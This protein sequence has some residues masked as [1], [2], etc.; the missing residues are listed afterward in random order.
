MKERLTPR[1]PM[2]ALR[3]FDNP[4]SAIAPNKSR[5]IAP[6]VIIDNAAID[7]SL[8]VNITDIDASPY[9]P[10]L[11]FNEEEIKLLADSISDQGLINPI[12]AR[13]KQDGRFEIISGERRFRAYILLGIA[14]IKVIV[15]NVDDKDVSIEA[16]TDNEARKDLCDYER[17]KSYHRIL[18]SKL[19]HNQAQLSRKIGVPSSTIS[20]CLSYFRL[21]NEACEILDQHPTLLGGFNAEVLAALTVEKYPEIAVKAIQLIRDQGISESA[22][23]NFAKAEIKKT[24]GEKPAVMES[25]SLVFGNRHIGAI[26]VDGRKII[27][28]CASDVNPEDVITQINEACLP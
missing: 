2:P 24:I 22:A 19:V 4:E 25:R 6:D 13:K 27:I 20:R 14:S 8:D 11:V 16:L 18:D 23:I 7:A 3:N 5:S 1:M 28:S 12:T 21:P 15:R 26:Q 17:G 9:Q 10:R